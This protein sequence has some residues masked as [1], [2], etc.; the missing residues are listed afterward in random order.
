MNILV[1]G[2]CGQL[3]RELREIAPLSENNYFF[4]DLR[5][6]EGVEA[7]DI[8]DRK[9]VG[10][11]LA[12]HDVQVLLNCVAYTDVEGAESDEAAAFRVNAAA[13]GMLA[14]ICRETDVFLIHISTDFV[15]DGRSSLPY[16]EE[17]SPAP[18]SV[19]GKTKLEGDRRIMASGCDHLIFRTSWLYSRF[20]NNFI[21]KIRDLCMKHD[22]IKVVIDQ[23]GNPT[24]AADLAGFLFDMIENRSF[25]EHRGLYNYSGEGVCS[26]YDLACAV[27]DL[28]GLDCAI[29]PCRSG[30]FPTKAVRPANSALDKS[31]LRRDFSTDIPNWRDSL[32]TMVFEDM[33]RG[34][35]LF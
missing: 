35:K 9:A 5:Q 16:T 23:I 13:P 4:A 2:A 33:S 6:E 11:I 3:G 30:E 7:L 20:G 27:K 34:E 31:A 17:D 1:A 26:R 19:Y 12:R 8:C 24:N 29:L 25:M 15:F 21:M 10:E 14:E 22:S 32:E 18:L 28:Y